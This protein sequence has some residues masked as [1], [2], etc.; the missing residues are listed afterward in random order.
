VNKIKPGATYID[1]LKRNQELLEDLITKHEKIQ[2][3]T[4][5]DSVSYTHLR[6]NETVLELV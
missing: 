2:G 3:D 1:L 5:I 6:A 4:Y